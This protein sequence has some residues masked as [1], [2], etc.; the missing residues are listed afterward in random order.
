M[1]FFLFYNSL[2]SIL[3]YKKVSFVYNIYY[4]FNIYVYLTYTFKISNII[5]K[6]KRYSIITTFVVIS[7]IYTFFFYKDFV[8]LV[9]LLDFYVEYLQPSNSN[10]MN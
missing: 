9:L 6:N 2:I 7:A 5:L 4:L 1:L 10:F 8:I 3:L